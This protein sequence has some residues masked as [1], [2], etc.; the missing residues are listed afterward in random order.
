M[1]S[2]TSRVT[3]TSRP[4]LQITPFFGEKLQNHKLSGHSLK[5]RMEG[6]IQT[7]KDYTSKVRQNGEGTT[8]KKK[9]PFLCL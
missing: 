9:G 6:K 1:V 4:L 7:D 5:V 2:L 8:D 3:G